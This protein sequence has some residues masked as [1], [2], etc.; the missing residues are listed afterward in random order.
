MLGLSSEHVSQEEGSQIIGRLR[1][2]P[3]H[4][5]ED[6]RPSVVLPVKATILAELIVGGALT[7]APAHFH[8][9]VDTHVAADLP[10]K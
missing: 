9:S 10:E 5:Y 8:Q 6:C 4:Q 7:L 2:T 1:F 3:Y